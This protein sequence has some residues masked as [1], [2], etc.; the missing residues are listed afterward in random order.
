[1]NTQRLL[2]AVINV[3]GGVAVLGSY[4]YGIATHPSPGNALWGGVSASLRPL[5]Q[6][7]M[8]AAAVGY[9]LFTYHLFF[10]VKPEEA[11]TYAGLGYGG[12][13]LLY[14]LI[15]VPSM[16]WMSLTFSY[17]AQPTA[18]GWV[19]VRGVLFAV[20]L[21]SIGM[22]VAIVR[23]GAGGHRA[24]FAAAVLGAALFALHTTVLDAI[25][26]TIYFRR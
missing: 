24:S 26:W 15:L 18:I 9:F 2:L 17:V 3:L 23:L 13:N 5:Y 19:L 10:V 14:L 16:L 8:L 6:A 20:A 25:V 7:S 4:A 21:G 22:L 12:F 1:M 11:R